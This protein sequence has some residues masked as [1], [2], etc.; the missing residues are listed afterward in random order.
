[1]NLEYFSV[2]SLRM[3]DIEGFFPPA[4]NSFCEETLYIYIYIVIIPYISVSI[5]MILVY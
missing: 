1:M 5:G 3:S 4:L 2:G